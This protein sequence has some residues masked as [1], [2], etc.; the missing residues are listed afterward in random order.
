MTKWYGSISNRIAEMATR[1]QPEPKVGMGATLLFYSDR[2]AATI[3]DTW[4]KRSKQWVK[5][6]RDKA[7]RT[8]NN[9]PSDCQE[10]SYEDDPDGATYFYRFN[11]KRWQQMKLNDETYRWNVVKEGPGLRIGERDEYYDYSF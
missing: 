7:T 6:R 2:H 11:G 10:Y 4:K 5:V 9:G 1:G 8:D 3:I